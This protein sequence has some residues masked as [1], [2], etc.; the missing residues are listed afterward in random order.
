[1]DQL[2]PF[3]DSARVPAVVVPF[4]QPPTATQ[5]ELEV[6]CTERRTTSLAPAG[7]GVD[8]D[9]HS[10]PSQRSERA[11]PLPPT[12]MQKE[13]EVQSV[14]SRTLPLADAVGRTPTVRA[15][16]PAGD[17]AAAAAGQ[18]TVRTSATAASV[19]APRR[20]R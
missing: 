10:T 20:A 16:G 15:L 6:H 19:P 11:L 18:T 3:H 2:S 7:S 13:L 4:D 9:T 1:M 12:A 17:A 5:A 8:N 14:A